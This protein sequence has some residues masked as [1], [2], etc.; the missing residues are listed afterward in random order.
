MC[1]CGGGAGESKCAGTRVIWNLSVA[2]SYISQSVFCLFA[3]HSSFLRLINFHGKS[4]EE[5]RGSMSSGK[6]VEFSPGRLSERRNKK[7]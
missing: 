4:S 7:M 2:N 3:D 1:K 5:S 6:L